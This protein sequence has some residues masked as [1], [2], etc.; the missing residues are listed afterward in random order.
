MKRYRKSIF[1]VVYSKKSNQIEYLVLKR[2]LHWNGWEFPKGGLKLLESKKRA[3]KR[4]VE[5]ETG[6]K[7]LE[8]RKFKFKGSYDYKKELKDRPGIKGQ[9]F[10]LFSAEVKKNKINLEKN[11]DKEHS[12]YR[13]LNFD[14]ALRKLT[15]PN[16]KKCLKEVNSLLKQ[17]D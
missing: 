11:K 2:K 12:D 10:Y 1:V 15:W 13:W 3:V 14:D 17:K 6:L 4:E 8:I 7:V 9:R 5:E 16:Q